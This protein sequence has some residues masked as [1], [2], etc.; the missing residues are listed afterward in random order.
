VVAFL[1]VVVMQNNNM[2]I[3]SSRLEAIVGGPDDFTK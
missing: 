3:T 2:C 1:P